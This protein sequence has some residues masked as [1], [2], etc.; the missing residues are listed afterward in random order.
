MKTFWAS[1]II[2]L[3]MTAAIV[4]NYF[5][6][7][8]VADNLCHMAYK[9]PTL[10]EDGCYE[11]ISQLD[12]Y[13]RRHEN[14]VELSV[15]FTDLNKISDEIAHLKSLSLIGEQADFEATR[16][17]LI[18]SIQKMRRLESISFKNII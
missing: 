3:I 18:N 8:S 6:I 5:Y 10:T 1:I 13:W 16:Q 9:T 7:N 11:Y 4:V 2:F 14:I 12:N 17:L 15:N